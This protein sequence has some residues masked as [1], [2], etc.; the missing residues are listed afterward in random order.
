ME[1]AEKDLELRG[2]EKCGPDG[3]TLLLDLAMVEGSLDGDF[4][5]HF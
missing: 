3:I 1:A 2:S 4:Y 5:F